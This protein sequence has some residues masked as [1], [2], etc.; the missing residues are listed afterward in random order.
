VKGWNK[1]PP[2]DWCGFVSDL[3]VKRTCCALCR[4]GACSKC[5]SGSVTHDRPAVL[6]WWRSSGE[7]LNLC[8]MPC[9]LLVLAAG[10]DP[11]RNLRPGNELR[12]ELKKL[13]Y[14]DRSGI[15]QAGRDAIDFYRL[16]QI[17]V[18]S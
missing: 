11:R 3:G 12:E 15:T 2:C 8:V 14:R 6:K 16:G 4:R 18:P 17:G 10:G 13:G 7:G 5:A 9:N 1:V